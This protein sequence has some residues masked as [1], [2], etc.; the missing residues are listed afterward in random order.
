[1]KADVVLVGA[2]LANA[3]IALRLLE[4]RPELDLLV[5]EREPS[6]G[7]RHVWS[8]HPSDLTERQREWISPLVARSWPRHEVRFPE[9]RRRLEGGYRSMTSTRLDRWLRERL[10]DR[11]LLGREAT[12]LSPDRVRLG[13]GSTLAARAVIDGRGARPTEAF[14]VAYQKFLGLHVELHQPCALDGPI[15]MDATVEQLDGYRFLYTLPFDEHSLLIEDTRYSD[16]PELA[17][18]E[19]RAAITGY[20]EAR[21]WRVRRVVDEEEGV[22]PIVLSGDID[23]FWSEADSGVP[24]AGMAAA[25]FQP[26]TGY[27]LAEAVGLADELSELQ[28]MTSAEIDRCVRRRSYDAWRRGGF[29]RLLNRMLFRAAEPAER[30]RVL[31][32][33]YGLPEPLIQRFYAGRPTLG[34]R[35]RVLSGKP[36]VPVRRA[37]GCLWPRARGGESG[38]GANPSVQ[39]ERK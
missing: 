26:T 32:R 13:D 2:G 12:E 21:G 8:F 30:Y 27:S 36:P 33:F 17:R 29:F 22:L 35:I 38:A 39:R 7:G 24:R 18:E 25:L 28:S 1:M 37:L 3:L 31:Q 5:V 4:R 34:D 20:A 23:A 19:M 6:A 14:Q 16:G 15:L 10:G 9:M 11:L